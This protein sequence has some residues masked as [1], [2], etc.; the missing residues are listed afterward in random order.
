MTSETYQ[1]TFALQ[2]DMSQ[3][4]ETLLLA[5][6]AA[7]GLHGRARVRLE[8]GFRCDAGGRSAEVDG[9]TDVG[10]AIARIFTALLNTSI[11]EPAFKVSRS[12]K[13]QCA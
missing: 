9:G 6:M 11:G 5:T 2:A 1:Y 3:V 10:E 4:E 8:A 7:E 13:E 12:V